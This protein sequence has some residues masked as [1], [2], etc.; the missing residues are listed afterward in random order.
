M[1]ISRRK[2]LVGTASFAAIGCL[3]AK[4]VI[5]AANELSEY[6]LEQA[7]IDITKYTNDR[8]LNVAWKPNRLIIH[9]KMMHAVR[10]VLA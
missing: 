9:P 10:N 3:S 7:I 4:A 8:G 5:P 1:S 2:F 6:T